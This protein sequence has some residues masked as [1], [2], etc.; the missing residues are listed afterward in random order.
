MGRHGALLLWAALAAGGALAAAGA[1]ADDAAGGPE[2]AAVKKV[3]MEAYVDGIHNFRNV[4]A[5]R[6]G[7]HPGFEM[8]ML[9]DGRLDKLPIYN[10]IETLEASNAKQPVPAGAARTI[11]GSFP[12]V[13]VTGDVALVKAELRREGALIFTDYLILHR[14]GDGWRIVGKA[15]HRH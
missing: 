3:V 6:K 4:E 7:F 8:L 13:D 9:R 14:F 5:V 15:F 11:E 2:Q 1:P 10:W 12:L